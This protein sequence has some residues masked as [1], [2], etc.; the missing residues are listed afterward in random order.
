MQTRLGYLV[1]LRGFLEASRRHGWLPRLP[2]GAVLYA[3]DMPRRGAYLPRFIPEHVMAQLESEASLARITDPTTR[4]LII[5]LI[6]TGLR[7]SDA[8]RIGLEGARR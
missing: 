2:A 4:H 7:S 5:V 1:A 3:D 8:C 6:E